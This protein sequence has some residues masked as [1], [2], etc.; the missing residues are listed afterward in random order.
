MKRINISSGAKWE[1]TV[2]SLVDR[3]MLIEIDVTVIIQE[4]ASD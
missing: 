1:D 2:K 4:L 3:D